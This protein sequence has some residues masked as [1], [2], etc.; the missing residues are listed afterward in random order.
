M[1]RINSPAAAPSARLPIVDAAR[2]A[3]LLAMFVYHFTWDLD[4]YDLISSDVG[5]GAWA[6]FARV[7]AGSFL[8]LVGM[9][10][11]LA[12]R[13]GLRPKPF[14]RRLAIVTGAAALVTL[15]TWWLTP[16]AFVYFGILHCIAVSSVLALPFLRLPV[17]VVAAAAVVCVVAP[18]LFA[19][20]SFDAPWLRWLGLMSYFP[21]T[22]DYE[23]L[24]PWFGAVLAGIA[25]AR[26]GLP[27]R[28]ASAWGGWKPVKPPARLLVWG[29]RHSLAIYLLHQ[30]LFVTAL[31]LV[32]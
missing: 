14:L 20:P 25:A 23:P 21:D 15:A 28:M 2:G 11:V 18:M 16:D 4:Y 17:S 29:G 9:S 27:T 3:S 19:G 8:F 12:S 32:A 13:G 30:P 10:L 6:V 31:Y 22:N 7:V 26:V 1:T 5:A 24:L